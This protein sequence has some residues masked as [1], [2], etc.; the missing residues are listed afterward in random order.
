MVFQSI[1]TP[2]EGLE[3]LF[4]R[5]GR[6]NRSAGPRILLTRLSFE[7][8]DPTASRETRFPQLFHRLCRRFPQLTDNADFDQSA[9]SVAQFLA[10]AAVCAGAIRLDDAR[11]S[12]GGIQVLI[13]SRGRTLVDLE[14]RRMNTRR[15]GLVQPLFELGPHQRSNPRAVE[16]HSSSTA[17]T[18]ATMAASSGLSARPET[19]E[20]HLPS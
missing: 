14:K 10:V 8:L 9:A 12:R 1:A 5:K 7:Y 2:S 4:D 11:Y 3:Y 18:T 19:I 13:T 15:W 17:S 20:A 16:A 6:F